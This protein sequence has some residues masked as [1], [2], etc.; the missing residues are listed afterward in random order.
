[1]KLPQAISSICIF[2]DHVVEAFFPSLVPPAPR[3]DGKDY[4]IIQLPIFRLSYE[5]GMWLSICFII[6]G[7]FSARRAERAYGSRPADVLN[8]ICIELLRR[9]LGL[10]VPSVV[11]SF[12]NV[13]CGYL[14]LYSWAADSPVTGLRKITPSA[15]LRV[16]PLYE[17]ARNL[18]MSMSSTWLT[19]SDPYN[20]YH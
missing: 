14:A 9:F 8:I 3:T 12:I 7:Y 10:F 19:G 5:A 15:F 17:V 18:F 13:L 4:S 16:T 2:N 1:V 6:S 11:S 20:I